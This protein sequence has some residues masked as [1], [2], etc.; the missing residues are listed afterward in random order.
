MLSSV[1]HEKFY[2]PKACLYW[3]DSAYDG[4]GPIWPGIAIYMKKL[5]NCI[6][7]TR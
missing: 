7:Q 1:E 4:T 5:N 3:A 2:I 6:D